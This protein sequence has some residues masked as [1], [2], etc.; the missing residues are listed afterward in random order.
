VNVYCNADFGD[1]LC[2]SPLLRGHNGADFAR[3]WGATKR[4]VPASR[5]NLKP[6]RAY[7]QR[8]AK[9]AQLRGEAAALSRLD[10]DEVTPPS[11]ESLG[12]AE[13][14]INWLSEGCLRFDL[15]ISHDGEINFLYGDVTEP[16]HVH[17][18]ENGLL[19]YYAKWDGQEIFGDDLQ[20]KQF[21]NR[22]LLRFV[23]RRK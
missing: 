11:T 21:P 18:D 5:L 10:L 19:S 9:L 15:K 16:F 6:G 12:A 14:F 22:E 4:E 23:D 1:E 13:T 3:I 17:I 8:S 2:V 20:A 7:T